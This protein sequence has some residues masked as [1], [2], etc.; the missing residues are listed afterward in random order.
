M[1]I[2][3]N[4]LWLIL[5]LLGSL[6]L[7]VSCLYYTVR[8]QGKRMPTK[9]VQIGPFHYS[10]NDGSSVD[11]LVDR[12]RISSWNRHLRLSD[13]RKYTKRR[14]NRK[15]LRIFSAKYTK[16]YSKRESGLHT[17]SKSS[18]E[19]RLPRRFDPST[20]RKLS[21]QRDSLIIEAR[22]IQAQMNAIIN[23]KML[24]H[25]RTPKKTVKKHSKRR[26]RK[27]SRKLQVTFSQIIAKF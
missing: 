20:S 5:C 1:D 12:L 27:K 3:S 16:S 7:I 17:A 24:R 8:E 19:I 4:H 10:S 14:R 26:K 13:E 2:S 11:W 9:L 15:S 25:W 21:I 6:Q 22:T 23:Q 18:V